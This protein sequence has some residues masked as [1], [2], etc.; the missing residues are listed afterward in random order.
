M[1]FPVNWNEFLLISTRDFALTLRLAIP[2]GRSSRQRSGERFSQTEQVPQASATNRALRLP[3][4]YDGPNVK[5]ISSQSVEMKLP[6]SHSLTE[7]EGQ[8]GFWFTLSDSQGNPVYRRVLQNPIRYDREVFSNDPKQ[9][10]IQRVKVDE[11]KG[12]FVVLVPDVA[13]ARTLQLFSPPLNLEDHGMA[14]REFARF[15][16]AHPTERE[17]K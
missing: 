6:P 7:P 14:A 1:N 5:L 3:V 13:A 10:S 11:P 8:S 15:N 16:L 4:Q 12:T 2:A 17:K 9:P